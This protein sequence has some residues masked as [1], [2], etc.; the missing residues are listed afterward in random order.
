M[1]AVT[2][3][4]GIGGGAAVLRLRNGLFQ[5]TMRSMPLDTM[6]KISLGSWAFSFGP[7]EADPWSWERF[8]EYTAEHGYDGVEI[9]AVPPHP[10]PDQYDTA[11]KCREL[12]ARLQDR[13]LGVSGY[14]V[15][16]H[17][18]DLQAA[19]P[20][21]VSPQRFVAALR[22]YLRFCSNAGIGALRMD[23]AS[24]P[25]ELDQATYEA[26]FANAVGCLRALAAAAA[27]HGVTLMWEFEP[28]FWLNKPSEVV[29][30]HEE[31]GHPH[32]KLLF[33]TSHAYLGAVVGSRHT[34]TPETLPGGTAEYAAL[35]RDRM[36]HLHLIDSDGELHDDDTST[37]IAFGQG[38][39][40]FPATLQALGPRLGEMAWWCVDFCFNP[41]GPEGAKL[42]VPF[43]RNLA[44]SL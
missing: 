16:G 34:G 26:R 30:L 41:A 36:G 32:F 20:A 9:N 37:H 15:N 2:R 19:P 12:V 13:G 6:P 24:R 14:A 8:V 1:Q 18:P 31:V 4:T 25:E 44:R 10:H 40:D 3:T 21:V 39:V 42:A 33:D 5:G 43:L 35:I 7:F 17:L 28:G 22:P 38:S 11:A 29:R 27:E 23:T